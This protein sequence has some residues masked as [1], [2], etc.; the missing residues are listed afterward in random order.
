MKVPISGQVTG[1]EEI[2][3]VMQVA[4]SH[5]YGGGE[6]TRRFER[7]IADYMGARFASFCNSGS[8]ALLLAMSAIELPKGAR[9]LTSAVNFPTTVNAIIQRGFVPVLVDADP[10]TLNAVNVEL[11]S[12][13]D[14]RGMIFAHTLG[15]PM[16]LTHYASYRLP[17]IEDCSDA[18]GG[19]IH[20][21]KIGRVGI[22]STA[23]FYPA[24]H[25]T[26]G[27]GG[28]VFTDS[29]K[30]K[31]LVERFRDWGRD[32]WCEPGED[33]TCG[34]R[35]SFDYDHKY[36]YSEIG[37]NLKASDFQAAVGV[38]QLDRLERFTRIR[39]E[40]QYY[41]RACLEGLPLEFVEATEGSSP[42]WFGLAFLTD[43][44]N[45]LA[46]FLDKKQIGNRPIMAGNIMRQPAY[47]DQEMHVIGDLKGANKIHE[48]GL[49]IG[50]FPGIT[51][52]MMNYTVE[53][54]HEFFK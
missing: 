21:K 37:Y 46:R 25:I 54:F 11:D 24:H 34:K 51:Q 30:L 3:N 28:A 50:C 20:G 19:T 18:L 5:H 7:G 27:E 38:A 2:D 32:C 35:F 42:S 16:D 14:V 15:N 49:W 13:Y 48:Q 1:Q 41:L 29:P 47:R 17:I 31:L 6:W 39:K 33:N 12:M 40:K 36:T 53:A 52:D 22:M 23:S 10:K 9:I 8:S 4:L 44:R 43:K 45:E 26:T